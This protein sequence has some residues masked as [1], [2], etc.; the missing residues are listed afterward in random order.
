M[1]NCFDMKCP[2][3]GASNEIDVA[4]TVW[5][6]LCHDG[7]DIFEAYNSDHEWNDDS[8]AVCCACDYAGTVRD[9]TSDEGGAA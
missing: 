3:C 4:A 8:A 5:V 9:F 2:R 1:S 7:T 6:R